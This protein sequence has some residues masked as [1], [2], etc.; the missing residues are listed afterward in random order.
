MKYVQ[1]NCR[2]YDWANSIVFLRHRELLEA[3]HESWVFWARGEHAQDN[4]MVKF[5][6]SHE[7]IVDAIMTRLD[8]KPGFHSQAA[9]R[10]L[11]KKL[12]QI[13]PDVVHLHALLGYYINVEM[14]FEWLKGHRCRVIWTLHECWAMTG[15]CMQFHDVGCRQ[16]ETGCGYS[17][18]CPL[19]DA[20]PQTF[21]KGMEKW[22]YKQKMTIFTSLP[23]DRMT[24]IVPSEWLK[25][26]VDR[27]FLSKYETIVVPHVV[28]PTVFKPTE[29][30]FRET[31]EIGDRFMVLGVASKWV[32]RKGLPLFLKL[33][34]MLNRDKYVVVLVGLR[35]CQLKDARGRAIGLPRID[36]QRVLATVYSAA[37]VL[38]NP[39]TEETFGMNVAEAVAC[40]TRAIVM[41][42]SA[43]AEVAD[44]LIET[45]PDARAI[46][47]E[48]EKL[49]S[50]RKTQKN[51]DLAQMDVC[52]PS[53]TLV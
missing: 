18:P 46:A 15:H 10:R 52:S 6:A 33:A 30:S 25:R 22:N 44:N 12:D 11:L 5:A 36:D 1:I 32:E 39:S 49:Q 17:T 31:H 2:S 14:L 48:I 24:L 20:Y 13:D 40:G 29:S 9:T 21:R 7:V 53:S 16:W 41:K 3:G 45:I 50:E 35:N 34:D 38:V 43:C 42:G 51:E 23:V 28:D 26:Y 47:H 37:D 27:S 19:R 4:R 8:G